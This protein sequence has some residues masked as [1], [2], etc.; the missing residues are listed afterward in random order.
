MGN[1]IFLVTKV[2]H[3]T[4]KQV[5]WWGMAL[6]GNLR[7]IPID[8]LIYLL[9]KRTGVLSV[10]VAGDT[11]VFELRAGTLV[12]ASQENHFLNLNEARAAF[13]DLLKAS[14][15]SYGFIGA[16]VMEGMRAINY[17]LARIFLE[18]QT[19]LRIGSDS[20]T[21]IQPRADL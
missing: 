18:T 8:Q 2:Y 3:G 9:L 1:A 20:S 11:F 15:G 13:R 19:D 16:P 21:G 17:P 4:A 14:E 6:Y 12:R 5:I 7:D 10:E